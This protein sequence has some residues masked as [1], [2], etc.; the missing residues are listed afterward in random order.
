MGHTAIAPIVAALRD[1]GYKGYLSAEI[2]PL[3]DS[4]AEARQ[5]MESFRAM[6]GK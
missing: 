3:P 6:A 5:T 4:D 2:V 1:I